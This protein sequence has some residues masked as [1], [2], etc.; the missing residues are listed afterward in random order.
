MQEKEEG[1]K[2]NNAKET[3]KGHRKMD[4]LIIILKTYIQ[5]MFVDFFIVL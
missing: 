1:K 3:L 4:Y 5:Y 2:I